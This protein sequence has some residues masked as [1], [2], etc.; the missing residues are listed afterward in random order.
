MARSELVCA[1]C[2]SDGWEVRPSAFERE[3]FGQI[4]YMSLASTGR[5]LMASS[6]GRVVWAGRY[7][8]SQ[9]RYRNTTSWRRISLT[10]I[11]TFP[12]G[13]SQAGKTPAKSRQ[14]HDHHG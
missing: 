1:D 14:N 13:R 7:N 9:Y 2:L 4:R 8:S 10:A 12:G 3:I 6:W 5:S 11:T